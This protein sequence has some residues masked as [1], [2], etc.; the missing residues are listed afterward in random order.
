MKATGVLALV[1]IFA[2]SAGAQTRPSFAG[3]WTTDPDP[4]AAAAAPA[5]RAGAG[6][7]VGGRAGAGDA[8]GARGGRAGGGRRGGGGRAAGTLGSGWGSTITITQDDARLTVEYAFFGRGD[9]QPPLRFAYA[10]D[11]SRTTNSVMMGRGIDQRTSRAAWN[12]DRLAITTTY[13]IPNPAGSG[14]PLTTEMTQVL[15]LES[16][17]SLVVETTRA[18]V[19]GGAPSTNRTVYRKL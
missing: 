4:A 14:A 9:M 5:G 2:V 16:P 12:G 8:G 1:G 3:R 10:L 19:M 11:G 18:G 7:A 6:G 13:T 17:A 15:S